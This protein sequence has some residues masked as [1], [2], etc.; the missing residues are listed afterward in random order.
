MKYIKMSQSDYIKRK[1]VS[2]VLRT[3]INTFPNVLNQK[4]YKQFAQYHLENTIK[5]KNLTPSQLLP[6]GKH[7]IFQIEKEESKIQNC[8]EFKV[9]ENTHDRPYRKLNTMSAPNKTYYLSKNIAYPINCK[10]L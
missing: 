6:A 5:N 8:P 4:Q 9:C 1:K 7:R 10:C 2:Q 3:D